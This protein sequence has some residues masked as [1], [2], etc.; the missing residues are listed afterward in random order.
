MNIVIIMSGGV[1]RRFGSMI[2][3]QYNLINGRPVIDYVLDAVSASKKT[4]KTIVVMDE[5]WKE[6]SGQLRASGCDIA[7]NGETRLESMKNALDLIARNYSCEKIIVLDAVAPFVYPELIDEYF[8]LLDKY[9]VVITAQKI[10]G[11]L[12]DIYDSALDREKFIV[13]QSPEGFRFSLLYENFDE[14]MPYQET[15]C[16]LPAGSK[17]YYNYEF[18]NNLKITYDFELKY[19]EYML[20]ALGKGSKSSSVAFFEKSI[21]YTAGIRENLLRNDREK[22]VQW[23]D[24]IYQCFPELIARWEISSFIPNQ[25]SRYGLVLEAVSQK[26]GEVV[27][28]FIPEFVGRFERELEAMNVLSSEFMCPLLES[29]EEKRVMLLRKISVAKYAKF[30]D[31]KKLTEFFR[32]VLE[33]SLEYSPDMGLKKIPLYYRELCDKLEHTDELVYLKNPVE[34]VL[35]R[36]KLLYEKV[37]SDAK[38]YVVHGDLHSM[39]ILDDGTRWWG[40]DPNGMIAP[41]ELE[42]VRF[43]RNDVRSHPEFGYKERFETLVHNFSRFVDKKRLMQM[44]VIDM[45]FCTYNSVFENEKDDETLLNLKLIEIAEEYLQKEER[46]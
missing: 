23:I 4:D 35:K 44:Y 7:P 12:T 1:G 20:N 16:M 10:T 32:T 38:L 29:D 42:L 28:K 18:K 13:T 14:D 33:Q 45:A 15:A 22:T 2:P 40:I 30:E 39:N 36:A 11:A 26:Y 46:K 6:Y 25:I 27:I 5:Q 17:R 21:L 41:K 24:S 8:D 43:I 31:N 19:A 34:V 9:D 3:K 37:F